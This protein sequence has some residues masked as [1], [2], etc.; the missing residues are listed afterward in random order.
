[1]KSFDDWFREQGSS[2]KEPEQEV[3]YEADCTYHQEGNVVIV[4]SLTRKEAANEP[5]PLDSK[6][7]TYEEIHT[8]KGIF[9]RIGG[10]VHCSLRKS[11][12]P[13]T[14]TIEQINIYHKVWPE[15][16]PEFEE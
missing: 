11:L 1:M 4:E 7:D 12:G 14:L 15:T 3:H 2:P 10:T 16:Y 13:F 9:T 5:F 6:L 8:D